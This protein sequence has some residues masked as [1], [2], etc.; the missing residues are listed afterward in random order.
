MA[1]SYDEFVSK[2]DRCLELNEIIDKHHDREERAAMNEEFVTLFKEC[3]ELGKGIL[4]KDLSAKSREALSRQMG[5]LNSVFPRFQAQVKFRTSEEKGSSR[6]R[7][8]AEDPG[9]GRAA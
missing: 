3:F 4:E 5:R 1:M 7:E 2:I 8:E 9:I 6:A